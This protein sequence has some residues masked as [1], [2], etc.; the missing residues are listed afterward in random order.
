MLTFNIAT[1]DFIDNSGTH[2]S[3]LQD[4][5]RLLAQVGPALDTF[6]GS[7]NVT[8]NLSLTV[9]AS[10]TAFGASSVTAVSSPTHMV[11]NYIVPTGV[12][13]NKVQTG[14]DVNGSGVD[15]F[16]TVTPDFMTRAGSN[17]SILV[18]LLQHEITHALGFYGY[19]DRTTGALPGNTESE[20]DTHV[21]VNGTGVSY[22]SANTAL[23]YGAAVPLTSLTSA[24]AIYHIDASAMTG[25]NPDIMQ[26]TVG[27]TSDASDTEL[28]ILKDLG[29]DIKKT[30]ASVDGHTFLPGSGAQTIVGTASATNTIVLAGSRND[31]SIA[32][33][34][35]TTVLA[36][37]AVPANV[38]SMAAIEHLTFADFGVNLRI[39]SDAASI[40]P[41]QLQNIT[42]LYVAFF[43]RTPD[44]DGLDYWINAFKSGQTI[45]QISDSFYAA[46]V[47]NSAQT[48]YSASSTNADFEKTVYK[49]VLGRTTVDPDGL[50]YWT[51]GLDNHSQTRGSLVNAIT[52]SAHTFKGDATYGY[53][54]NLLDNKDA[55]AL[56]AAVQQGLTYLSA[57]SAISQG[58][59]IL[60]AV[61]PTDTSAAIKL[62]GVFDAHLA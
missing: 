48:G 43:N 32:T 57:S 52:N 14:I 1:S 36:S 8:M 61:T 2:A 58:Q 44:A 45:N 18:D 21:V 15:A 28:A 27:A 12:F 39:A 19:R 54:A 40:T 22:S 13:A 26:P 31:Y 53:V 37:K 11:G 46:G 41:A 47:Q 3:L 42:E 49:N 5:A 25:P 6:L 20:F 56:V 9:A 62:I 55:V 51:G 10:P 16:L 35:G 33:S 29:Y 50:A 30:L 17:E 4:I 38:V 7:K 34:G 23:I 59:A 24:S 60:Q